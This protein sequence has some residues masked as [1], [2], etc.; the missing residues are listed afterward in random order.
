MRSRFF[1]AVRTA[2]LTLGLC[3]AMASQAALFSDDEARRAILDLRE[4]AQQ[5][6]DEIQQLRRTLLDQQNQG[7]ALRAEIARLRGEK[8]ELIQDIKRVQ[9]VTQVQEERLRKL[10]PSIVKIDGN[11]FTATPDEIKAYEEALKVFRSGNFKDAAA[12]FQDFIRMYGRSGFVVPSYFWLGNAQ[13]ANRDYKEAIKNFSTLLER[14]PNHAR[15]PEALL[16]IANCHIDLKDL[17]AARKT[18]EEVMSKYPQS[19]SAAAA[20]E[21]LGKL[22]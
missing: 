8:E 7:E 16:S 2:L 6:S 22:K 11:E 5:L 10:E 15:A 12:V 17:K 21:R 18:L 14:A 13:Y 9:G 19:E 20:K 4:R 3:G 1:P